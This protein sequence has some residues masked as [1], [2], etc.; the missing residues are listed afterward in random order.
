[1]MTRVLGQFADG[2][3]SGVVG[4]NRFWFSPS[5]PRLLGLMR[6]FV[7]A[8]LVY[9]HV[10][11]SLALRTFF[12]D[13]GV[14][15]TEYARLLYA[16]GFGLWTHFAWI[17]SSWAMWTVHF[18]AIATM[19]LFAC[20]LWT[21]VT[22]IL[23]FL[24][25]VSYA[26]RA[27]GALFGL[28]QISCFLTLYLAIGP[29]GAAFSIDQWLDKKHTKFAT[30]APSVMANIA[31]RLMQI[32][33]CV[34]YLFAGLSKLQGGSWWNGEAIWGAIASADYQ[35]WDFTWLAHAMWFVNLAT[36][37]AIA[38]EISYPFLIWNRSARPFYLALAVMIHLGIGVLMGMIP[39]GTI[40]IIAN[41]S[42]LPANIFA[43]EP[44]AALGGDPR[45][46]VAPQTESRRK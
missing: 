38:W 24:F 4:W 12:A 30:A 29:S 20:G 8:M 39:F 13:E 26:H 18:L 46:Q 41:M 3:R 42:F 17:Q 43:G 23:S 45:A 11:W 19:C 6:V 25:L 28:D 27:T 31:L 10:V 32:H 14:L 34:V 33:L 2:L 16:D 7:G 9:T 40:M 22:A 35:T 37:V 44:S 21:R 15:P 1:M 5:S 36:L